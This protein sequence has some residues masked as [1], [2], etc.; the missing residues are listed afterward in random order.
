[1]GFEHVFYIISITKWVGFFFLKF[2]SAV[3]QACQ[4]HKSKTLRQ[5]S[6]VLNLLSRWLPGEENSSRVLWWPASVHIM[7]EGPVRFHHGWCTEPV[8]SNQEEAE[9]R[10]QTGVTSPKASQEQ[11]C[12]IHPDQQPDS[13]SNELTASAY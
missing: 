8:L 11:S 5:H 3:L 13:P 12:S 6:A 10:C 7:G 9:G 1:M 2:V 4:S